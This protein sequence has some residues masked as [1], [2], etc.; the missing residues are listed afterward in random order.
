MKRCHRQ[1]FTIVELLVVVALM[2]IMLGLAVPAFQG[3]GRGQKLQTAIFQ[4]NTSMNLARQMA[5]TTRQDVHV[6]FPDDS[7][8]Y[9]SNTVHLAFSA[10]AIVGERD[11][12]IGDWRVLP[13]G[14]VFEADFVP[15]AET[16]SSQ[17]F[18]IFRQ[19]A[20]YKKPA[21]LEPSSSQ[22]QLLYAFTF[23][24]DGAIDHAGINRKAVYLTEG[25]VTH[26]PSFSV[27][28]LAYQPNS[29][30]F[31]LEFRPETGQTRMREYNPD[32]GT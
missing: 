7:I 13:R 4:L 19:S 5:I 15:P 16:G 29:S 25:F 6:V 32:E 26:S 10:Y 30:V 14:V 22:P 24:P 28:D 27:S 17:P 31:G 9:S 11:G 8:N 20:T 12:F 2:A 1:G 23:R 3:A 18:N 21:Q